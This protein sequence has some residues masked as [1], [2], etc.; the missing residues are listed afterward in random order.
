MPDLTF[1]GEGNARKQLPHP[2]NAANGAVPLD[3]T[4][5]TSTDT[6]I[7]ARGRRFSAAC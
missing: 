7:S 3:L 5:N 2:R 4:E 6:L 1:R